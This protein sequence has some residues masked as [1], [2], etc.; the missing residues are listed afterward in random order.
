MPWASNPSAH[1]RSGMRSSR[2]SHLASLTLYNFVI[3]PAVAD[4]EV[5]FIL[6]LKGMLAR[7]ALHGWSIDG[8]KDGVFPHRWHAVLALLQ[9][10][11]DRLRGFVFANKVPRDRVFERNARLSTCGWTLGGDICSGK[12]RRARLACVESL[13]VVVNS[14]RLGAD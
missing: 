13:Q 3:E 7:L 2:I 8:G 12:R 5:A 14:R 6:R 1:P 10:E 9:A 4:T 11:L